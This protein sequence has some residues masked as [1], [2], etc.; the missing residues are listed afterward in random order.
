MVASFAHWREVNGQANHQTS[1]PS[2]S[3]KYQT[4]VAEWIEA[5][6]VN[7]QAGVPTV[8]SEIGFEPPAPSRSARSRLPVLLAA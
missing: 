5:D 1:D 3:W 2:E 7:I 4:E 8:V 6:V